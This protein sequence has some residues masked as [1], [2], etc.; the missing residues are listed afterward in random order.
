MMNIKPFLLI[1]YLFLIEHISTA[2]YII[3][4]LIIYCFMIYLLLILPHVIIC[5][6]IAHVESFIYS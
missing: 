2:V 4:I 6:A 5:A 1:I 3:E